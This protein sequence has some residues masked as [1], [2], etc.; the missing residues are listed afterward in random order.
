M[1]GVLFQDNMVL[2]MV[3]RHFHKFFLLQVQP[4]GLA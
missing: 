3:N 2:A 4:L 1:A